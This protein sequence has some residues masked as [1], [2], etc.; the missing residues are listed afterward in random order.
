MYVC[1]ICYHVAEMFEI[2]HILQWNLLY[3]DLYWGWLLGLLVTLVIG[4]NA[5]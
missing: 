3:P 4:C 5:L 2:F 1:I